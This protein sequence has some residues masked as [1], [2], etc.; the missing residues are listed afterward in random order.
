MAE[1]AGFENRCSAC[2]TVGSNPTLSVFPATAL[3]SAW[4]QDT[5]KGGSFLAHAFVPNLCQNHCS[6]ETAL[7]SERGDVGD[8]VRHDDAYHA[9]D[10]CAASFCCCVGVSWVGVIPVLSATGPIAGSP[11]A[12]EARQQAFLHEST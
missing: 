7:A 9:L 3:A 2:T 4:Q 6:R 5:C 11:S 1:R 12:G 10:F 8:D